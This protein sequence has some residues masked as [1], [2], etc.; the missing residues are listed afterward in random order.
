MEKRTEPQ[1]RTS[2]LYQ[3]ARRHHQMGELGEAVTL[4][5]QV[6]K[7]RPRHT[8]TLLYLGEIAWKT[9]NL[10]QASVLLNRALAIDPQYVEAHD[11]LWQ[12]QKA[13]GNYEAAGHLLRQL[14]EL[15][16]H[17]GYNYYQLGLLQQE[18]GYLA[19]ARQLFEL[20]VRYKSDDG[21]IFASYGELLLLLGLIEDAAAKYRQAL[22]FDPRNA[23]YHSRLGYLLSLCGQ[24]GESLSHIERAILFDP[25]SETFQRQRW[26]TLLKLGSYREGF[27]EAERRI[28]LKEHSVVESMYAAI[29]RWDGEPFAGRLLI[30]PETELEDILQYARYLPQVKARGGT[31]ILA[32]PKSLMKLFSNLQCVDEIV[33]AAPFGGGTGQADI[34]A[35][36]VSLPYLF[37]T[38]I[39]SIPSHTPYL[40]A[41]PFLTHSWVRRLNWKSFRVG[42]AWSLT[43]DVAASNAAVKSIP[44]AGIE[45]LANLPGI[46][47]HSLQFGAE[48]AQVAFP[49]LP[50]I[51]DCSGGLRD[52]ADL[53]ALV[54]NL[55]LIIAADSP[56]AHL[57]AA[58]GRPVWTL[59]P[60]ESNWRW[61]HRREDSLWY[62][63]MRLFR[64][65]QPGDW[66][67]VLQRVAEALG[68]K[69]RPYRKF[70]PLQG[71]PS[72][73][74]ADTAVTY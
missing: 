44:A 7:A 67:E 71:N 60:F 59:L 34:K 21:R 2:L 72:E 19:D 39:D 74:F 57:A 4:Y 1:T 61:L 33:E 23:G 20:A 50:P 14:I 68:P 70:Q 45:Q 5:G 31:L 32:L 49:K 73:F 17:D 36:I 15:R 29:P 47:W 13:Q 22:R 41:D 54:T 6:L 55:D 43:N 10:D 46:S 30:Y 69:S 18:Q 40:F 37:G 62:P 3:Q 24:S 53:A 25:G 51:I 66:D 58:L 28:A 11:L 42:L 35:S 56:S 52:Y 26:E 8:P 63:T 48:A 12:V 9:E 27:A 38:T 65:N 64:Q 16:R